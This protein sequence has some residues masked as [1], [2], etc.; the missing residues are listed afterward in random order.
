MRL[1][2]VEGPGVVALNYMWLPTWLGQN[3]QF[4]KELEQALRFSIVGTE[5]TEEGLDKINIQ[6]LE[7]IANRFPHFEG[8][9]DYLDGLKFVAG[10]Q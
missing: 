4:K 2:I 3:A 1:V 10:G 8:L 6:I 9:E 5:L 7:Y